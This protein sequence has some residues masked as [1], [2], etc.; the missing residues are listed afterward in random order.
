[1]LAIQPVSMNTNPQK[2]SFQR[3][4]RQ[5]FEDD[6]D[7]FEQQ[8][9]E[10]EG[11]IDDNRLPG[12]MRKFLKVANVVT[13]A[14]IAGFT[15]ACATIASA[16]CG[17]NTFNKLVSNKMVKNTI[18]GF[19]PMGEYAGKGFGK[20]KHYSADLVRKL[21]GKEKGQTIIDYTKKTIKTAKDFFKKINPFETTDKFDK[22]TAKVATGLGV[23]AGAASA[24][25]KVVEKSEQESGEF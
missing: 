16:T 7:F 25:A 3:S 9:R 4:D 6:R 8:K 1:M 20:L 5:S 21:F 12:G 17:K 15:V 23:G 24:Y 2:V 14:L 22:A 11:L 18:A 10:I 13:D 19:E